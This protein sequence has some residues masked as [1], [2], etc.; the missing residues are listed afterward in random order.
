MEEKN[1]DVEQE[2]SKLKKFVEFKVKPFLTDMKW[3]TKEA[4]TKGYNFCKE[5]K[6]E[7]AAVLTV[8]GPMVLGAIREASKAH[9]EAIAEREQDLKTYDR[10][11]DC[12]LR[13]RR[14]LKPKEQAEL[15]DRMAAGEGKTE[16]LLDMGLLQKY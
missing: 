12:Y 11:T 9:R 4:V 14:P 15:A 3:K 5:H 1:K 6:T 8:G 2:E 16:I 13:L 10:R 7:V